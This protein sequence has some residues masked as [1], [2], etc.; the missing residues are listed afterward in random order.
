MRA[1]AVARE[2]IDRQ[3]SLVD[4]GDNGAAYGLW[5]ELLAIVNELMLAGRYSQLRPLLAIYDAVER[6]GVKG[7]MWETSYVAFLEDLKLP[8]EQASLRQF[9]MNCPPRLEA[10][11]KQDRAIP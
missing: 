2:W 5:H 3:H 6:T 7:E 9:W 10:A 8:G 4:V 1:I 11:L